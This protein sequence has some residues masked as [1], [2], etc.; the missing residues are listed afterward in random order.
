MQTTLGHIGSIIVWVLLRGLL[1][2]QLFVVTYLPHK[3]RK[4]APF[5]HETVIIAELDAFLAG[6]RWDSVC[7]VVL[8]DLN[9]KL[10]RGLEG[11]TWQ[12]SMHYKS[13]SGGEL[14]L[15][16][17]RDQH[18]FAASTDFRPGKKPSLGSATY[19]PFK[20]T[21]KPTQI[22]HIL[23]STRWRSAVHVYCIA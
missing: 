5:Q 20:A 14:V 2:D 22:D 16:M 7:K 21:A 18:L 3:A 12:Y 11:L 23:I 10:K 13:D 4:K 6:S 9:A 15:Q 19:I 1:R 8:G 17:L